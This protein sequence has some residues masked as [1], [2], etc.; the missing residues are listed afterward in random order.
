MIREATGS[1]VDV[2][3]G[4]VTTACLNGT[5]ECE[6]GLV[7]DLA[8]AKVISGW[9]PLVLAGIFAASLSSALASLVSA[10]KVF[11]A[12]CKD[13]IF[14]KIEYFAHGVGAGDEPKRAYVLTFFI[15]AAFI[16][17]GEFRDGGVIP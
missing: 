9:V 14:P 2:I 4:N 10:P 8:A 11:Q 12:V 16:A 6:Y 5:L 1:I 7:N 13:K 17:I 3:A 15:A